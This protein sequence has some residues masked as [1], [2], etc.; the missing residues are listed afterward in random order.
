MEV[1]EAS[2][3]ILE[4]IDKQ[5]AINKISYESIEQWKNEPGCLNRFEIIYKEINCRELV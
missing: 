4:A 2:S 1:N 3:I 5:F